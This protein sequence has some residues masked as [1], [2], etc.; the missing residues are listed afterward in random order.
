MFM[1]VVAVGAAGQATPERTFLNVNKV[2][3]SGSAAD[4]GMPACDYN[5]GIVSHYCH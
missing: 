4:R 5:S 1:N 2:R 3:V